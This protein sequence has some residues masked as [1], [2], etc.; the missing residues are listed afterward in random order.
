M[1]KQHYL[2]IIGL[3]FILMAYDKGSY[4]QFENDFAVRLR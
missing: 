4:I 2:Q 3:G 1:T